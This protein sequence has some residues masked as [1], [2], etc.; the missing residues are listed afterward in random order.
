M[1]VY[2]VKDVKSGLFANPFVQKTNGTAIRAFSTACEDPNTDLNKYPSD[3]S[4]YH[5]GTFNP[6]TG[7]LT[8]PEKMQIANAAEFVETRL[9]NEEISEKAKII[10][11]QHLED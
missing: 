9:S 3:F 11:E 8:Q 1:N 10:R 5:I 2:C 6:E 4:L 7:D